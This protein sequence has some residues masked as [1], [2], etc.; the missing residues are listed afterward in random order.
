ML[1]IFCRLGHGEPE[2]DKQI[3]HVTSHRQPVAVDPED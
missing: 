1:G 3:I 2:D